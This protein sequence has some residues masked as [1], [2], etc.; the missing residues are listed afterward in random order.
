MNIAFEVDPLVSNLLGKHSSRTRRHVLDCA[1]AQ[2]Y[3]SN[4][5]MR[6]LGKSPLNGES[7]PLIVMFTRC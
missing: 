4:Y 3:Y 6:T 7:T 1:Y 2:L 5:L